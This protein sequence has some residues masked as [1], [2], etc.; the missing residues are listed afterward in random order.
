VLYANVNGMKSLPGKGL[1]GVCPACGE[2]V[3]PKCGAIVTH[4][5]S[6]LAGSECDPW[7]EKIGPWHLSWQNLVEAHSA[8][9]VR[10][11]H[12]AD[13]LGNDDVVIE[14]QHSAISAGDIAAR[15]AFY[16][17]MV[18]L[19]D[20]TERFDL[21]NTG[22]RTFF[23]LLRTKHL[24]LCTKPVFLDFGGMI[25]E[26][27]S[28][29]DAMPKLDGYGMTRT[30]AWFAERFLSSKLRPGTAAPPAVIHR[31]R[32]THHSRF[33]KLEHPTLWNDPR[34]GTHIRIEK[35]EISLQC[36]WY[37]Q[38]RP[39][40]KEFEWE[41]LIDYHPIIANGW[42]KPEIIA[43]EQFLK[44]TIL[45]VDGLLRVMPSAAKEIEV[46]M[47][48]AAAR[49]YLARIDGH[50]AAGRVPIL[51][52]ETKAALLEKARQYE[53]QLYRKR[54]KPDPQPSL[55]G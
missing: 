26:V 47:T 15:E 31:A 18:W 27:E 20:A 7:A 4:H 48:E 5:W 43:T 30:P 49:A 36:N 35:D 6:H 21:L 29:T 42:T 52:D 46:K 14:L 1:R 50:I 3:T 16:G 9:V 23:S 53:Q 51:K 12:R 54:S 28:F 44:G 22:L 11:P 33:S 41:R 19:F 8:E 38:Q 37:R 40:A 10:A 39:G 13:I 55:F 32:W 24:A 34:N 45:V 2:T 25:V 17:N